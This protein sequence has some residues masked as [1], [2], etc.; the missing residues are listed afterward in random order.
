MSET[1]NAV[2]VPVL[3]IEFNRLLELC[4]KINLIDSITTFSMPNHVKSYSDRT[5]VGVGDLVNE[6][7]DYQKEE[8]KWR[9]KESKVVN[10]ICTNKSITFADKCILDADRIIILSRLNSIFIIPGE[11]SIIEGNCV[12]NEIIKLSN[13]ISSQLF[14]LQFSDEKDETSGSY[15]LR[16]DFILVTKNTDD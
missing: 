15:E 9:I 8:N 12:P 4:K 16:A 14:L 3:E 7:L 13:L 10:C 2:E 6:L 5:K 1:D 11:K